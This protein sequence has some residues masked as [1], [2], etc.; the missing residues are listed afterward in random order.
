MENLNNTSKFKYL[1]DMK[2]IYYPYLVASIMLIIFGSFG[3]ILVIVTILINKVLRKSSTYLINLN[4]AF[5]DLFIS[6][7]VNT[8]TCVGNV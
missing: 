5:A 3:N 6:I 8:F 1:I 2:H 7:V 4:L